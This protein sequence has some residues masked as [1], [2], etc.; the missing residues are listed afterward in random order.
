MAYIK[1]LPSLE[2][3]ANQIWRAEKEVETFMEEEE[4]Y[5]G[6]RLRLNGWPKVIKT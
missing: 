2:E 3:N 6:K 1:K 4:I 5:W